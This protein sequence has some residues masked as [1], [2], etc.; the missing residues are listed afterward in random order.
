MCRDLI[1]SNM[2]TENCKRNDLTVQVKSSRKSRFKAGSELSG[3]VNSILVDVLE[4]T[5]DDH[6]LIEL[7]IQF[8]QEA[9]SK[10]VSSTE[11]EC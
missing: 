6:E 7:K 2:T 8:N 3:K 5:A 10:E 1:C 9:C 4:E 11:E